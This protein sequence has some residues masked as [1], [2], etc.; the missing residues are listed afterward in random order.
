M[1]ADG[2]KGVGDVQLLTIQPNNDLHEIRMGA[3]LDV[4]FRAQFSFW[5]VEKLLQMIYS[6]EVT[7]KSVIYI[8][9]FWLPGFEMI[10]YA[11][12]IKGIRPKVYAFCHAQSVDPHDFTH[13]MRSWMRPMEIGWGNWLT[14][15]FVAAE[16]L[17]AMLVAGNVAR[18]EKIH[19][20]GTVMRRQVLV[21]LGWMKDGGKLTRTK[22]VIFA[23][24]PDPEKDPQF[25]FAVASKMRDSGIGFKYLSG[26]PLPKDIIGQASAAKVAVYDNLSKER[27]FHHL[28]TASLAFNCAK[29]DFIG[30]CQLDALAA[31]CPVLCP[32]YLTFP[33]LLKRE[34]CYLYAPGDVADACKHVTDIVNATAGTSAGNESMPALYHRFALHYEFSVERMVSTMFEM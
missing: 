34:S 26:R 33:T 28:Q 2:I 18:P 30:Y 19:V 11:C 29:Q 15:I 10:P 32:D 6:G 5:Q 20:C 25:F 3:V 9:D 16:E 31:G 17:K 4:T 23:S 22:S 12:H 14:G 24:R 8:E 13:R 1:F 21:D 27:Y 7:D